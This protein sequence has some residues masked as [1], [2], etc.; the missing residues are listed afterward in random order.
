MKS[1]VD[2]MND[3]LKILDKLKEKLDE[4]VIL[5]MWNQLYIF[6]MGFLYGLYGR[7]AEAVFQGV[8]ARHLLPFGVL[9]TIRR[10]AKK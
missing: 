6:V 1:L 2:F 9:E 10:Y 4:R 5:M 3:K 7:D 8:V